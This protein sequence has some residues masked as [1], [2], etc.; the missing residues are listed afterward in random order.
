VY[1]GCCGARPYERRRSAAREAAGSFFG[2]CRL[3]VLGDSPGY[4]GSAFGRVETSS[5]TWLLRRW[6][7][8]FGEGRLRFIHRALLESRSGGFRGVLRLARTVHGDTIV[9]VAG[10]LYDAQELTWPLEAPPLALH[11]RVAQAAACWVAGARTSE[12]EPYEAV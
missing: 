7:S 2:D 11:G 5:G 6:P 9:G 1:L 12:N 3:D 10:H 4:S 8:G